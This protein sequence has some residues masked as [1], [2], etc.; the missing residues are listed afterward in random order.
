MSGLIVTSED[1]QLLVRDKIIETQLRDDVVLQ[2]FNG[3]MR[4]SIKPILPS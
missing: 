1:V 4:K 2:L 3:M